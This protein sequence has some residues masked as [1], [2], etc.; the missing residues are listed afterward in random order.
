KQLGKLGCAT[1]WGI[2]G[3]S[4]IL[5]E[6][7]VIVNGDHGG[8]GDQGDKG[9]D[10]GP[11]WLWALNKRTG[12]VVW[13]T[14]RNQGIGWGTPVVVTTP[15]GRTEL[16]LNSPHGVWAYEPRTGKELW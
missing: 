1:G 4:P 15:K 12:E 5:F 7:L 13:K 14:E 10:Y 8:M 6:D 16:V 3:A 11:S 2:G 9:V